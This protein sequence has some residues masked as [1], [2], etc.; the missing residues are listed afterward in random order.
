MGPDWPGDSEIRREMGDRGDEE[1]SEMGS[2]RV[3]EMG[4]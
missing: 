1:E 3:R 2:A 4:R